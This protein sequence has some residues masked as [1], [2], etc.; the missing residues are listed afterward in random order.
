MDLNDM[1][2]WQ[3]FAIAGG[4]VLVIGVIAYFLPV[5]K[6]KLPAVVTAAF[7]G[8]VAGLALGVLLMAGFGYKA[9]RDDPLPS[10]M[11]GPP[12]LAGAPKGGM[13]MP[14]GGGM[15]KGGLPKG[16]FGAPA[17]SSRDQLASLLTT[18]D[19][20]ADRPV[21]V[22]LT[23]EE[24][25]A[26]VK[27]LKALT[28]ADEVNNEEAKARLDSILKIVEKHQKTLET[29]GFRTG[30]PPKGGS[31]LAKDNPNPF[32][33]GPAAENV[34]SLVERLSK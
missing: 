4:A 33:T 6:L 8:V 3:Y 22:N 2:V 9:H 20:V 11:S 24:K 21:T 12:G 32:K 7:G 30:P 17:P 13:A 1:Q 26:I 34:K 27:E 29:V 15:P 18:L 31:S 16:N 28:E 14:K 10:D 25:A 5:G 19:T 23:T